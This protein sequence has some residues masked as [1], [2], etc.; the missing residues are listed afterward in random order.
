MNTV[1]DIQVACERD[2][3]AWAAAV[4]DRQPDERIGLATRLADG[5]EVRSRSQVD[6]GSDPSLEVWPVVPCPHILRLRPRDDLIRQIWEPP[7]VL[8]ST[9]ACRMWRF[10]HL[11]EHAEK[12]RSISERHRPHLEDPLRKAR[13]PVKD[14][15]HVTSRCGLVGDNSTHQLEALLDAQAG[16]LGSD[17]PGL[18]QGFWQVHV[19]QLVACK[20]HIPRIVT[21]KPC[22]PRCHC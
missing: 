11:V 20:R 5:V 2:P 7:H 8:G 18:E 16:R 6:P 19:V 17:A 9:D 14:P 1:T 3:G 13:A 21:S 15:D 12:H 4:K 10:L 22:Q